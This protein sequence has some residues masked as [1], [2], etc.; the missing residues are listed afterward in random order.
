MDPFHHGDEHAHPR[1][2]QRRALPPH[3]YHWDANSGILTATVP[4]HT[5]HAPITVTYQ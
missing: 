4:R 3:A 2:R 1:H 5:V